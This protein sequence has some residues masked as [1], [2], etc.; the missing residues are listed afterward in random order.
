MLRLWVEPGGCGTAN[1][2][3]TG[4]T[5]KGGGD[6]VNEWVAFL[7]VIIVASVVVL[8]N[9]LSKDGKL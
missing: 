9:E 5:E 3:H 6:Q 8:L 2:G 1:A 4:K 7:V